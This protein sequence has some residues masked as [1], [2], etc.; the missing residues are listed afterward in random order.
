MAYARF[1][2]QT[3][4]PWRDYRSSDLT[5]AVILRDGGP[6]EITRRAIRSLAPRK[7]IWSL[8]YRTNIA[9]ASDERQAIDAFLVVA[10][11]FSVTP[12]LVHDPKDPFQTVLNI[13]TGDGAATVFYFPTTRTLENFRHFPF[14]DAT[15]LAY[16]AGVLVATGNRTID[17]DA[18]KVTF[19][20]A[21]AMAAAVTISYDF[22]RLAL[23]VGDSLDWQSPG[24]GYTRVASAMPEFEEIIRDGSG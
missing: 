14:D 15:T 17:T 6:Y 3:D 20:A 10:R 24:P 7:W 21:P 8:P 1:N 13:G 22:Y 5:P 23:F 11:K 2:L 4:L 12:F 19:A 18:R 9:S 16:K